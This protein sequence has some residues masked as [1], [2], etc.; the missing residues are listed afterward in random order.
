MYDFIT[1][2]Q[3]LPFTVAIGVMIGLALLELL[4]LMV[5]GSLLGLFDDVALEGP[6]VD[7]DL[8]ADGIEGGS[9]DAAAAGDGFSRILGWFAVGQVPLL[10]V[11]VAFLTIFGL[12]GLI[13]Q[14]L[15][16]GVSGLLLPASLASIPALIVGTSTT[17][18]V[19]FG[20][21]RL[22]PSTETSVV[23][24]DSFVGRVAV[25]TLGS[26][27]VGQPAQAKLKDEHGQTHYLM[28]EPDRE[29][30][31]FQ[32]GEHVLLVARA[33]G[34]FKGILGDSKALMD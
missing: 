33:D 31:V 23:S 21:A 4:L 12:T 26:A 15:W 30:V 18:W 16:Q 32:E 11:I 6:D 9:G 28:V 17:R 8:N 25:I 13:L 34:V 20:L 10:V 5:G 3:N 14:S 27:R 1:S 2:A 29:Q 19:A 7:L 24:T 22:I